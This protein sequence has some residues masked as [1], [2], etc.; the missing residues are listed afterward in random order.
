[1]KFFLN[2]FNFRAKQRF[3]AIDFLS[4]KFILFLKS[5]TRENERTKLQESLIKVDS[6]ENDFW[7]SLVIHY[8]ANKW[9]VK[10]INLVNSRLNCHA[11]LLVPNKASK[12]EKISK[13]NAQISTKIWTTER[14]LDLKKKSAPKKNTEVQQK[15][16][17]GDYCPHENAKREIT[18]SLSWLTKTVLCWTQKSPSRAQTHTHK[19][20]DT[21]S[22]TPTTQVSKQMCIPNLTHSKQMC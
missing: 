12:I 7:R 5:T 14:F 21:P 2:T 19:H 9:F 15:Q 10:Y 3:F 20:T 18:Q 16:Q 4:T 6:R 13:T 17:R 11:W 1:M 22:L 8:A